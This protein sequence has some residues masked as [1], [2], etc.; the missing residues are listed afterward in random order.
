M[1]EDKPVLSTQ[2]LAVR[3]GVSETK[4]KEWAKILEE[5]SRHHLPRNDR[6]GWLFPAR[7]VGVME[8]AHRETA[9]IGSFRAALATVLRSRVLMPSPVL[10]LKSSDEARSIREAGLE[11]EMRLSKM[12]DQVTNRIAAIDAGRSLE[13]RQMAVIARSLEPEVATV[14]ALMA[15]L[16]RAALQLERRSAASLI[17]LESVLSG[18]KTQARYVYVALGISAVC[19]VVLTGLVFWLVFVVRRPVS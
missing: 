17:G 11:A 6:G 10:V 4:I 2:Q 15:L 18:V 14:R 3:L 12:L 8:E 7:E 1:S 9:R 19:V 16:Q 5:V 13:D